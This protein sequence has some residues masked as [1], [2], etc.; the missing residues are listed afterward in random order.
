M[1]NQH[2]KRKKLHF[3]LPTNARHSVGVL[4]VKNENFITNALKL[5]TKR[6]L[7]KHC[8][9]SKWELQI[10][11]CWWRKEKSYTICH[12]IFIFFIKSTWI[13]SLG[14]KNM[15]WGFLWNSA[16]VNYDLGIIMP[17]ILLIIFQFLDEFTCIRKLVDIKKIVYMNETTYSCSHSLPTYWAS[18]IFRDYFSYDTVRE[19]Q[20]CFVPTAIC[21][22]EDILQSLVWSFPMLC[23]LIT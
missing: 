18:S 5:S 16:T 23:H 1:S 21:T 7:S 8:W 15:K 10:Q 12:A 19:N 3:L 13:Q 22:H 2:F 9:I 17:L 6:N 4:T 20:A 14:Y 11:C